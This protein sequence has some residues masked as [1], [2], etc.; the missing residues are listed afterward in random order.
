MEDKILF[1]K[2]LGLKAPWFITEVSL[3]EDNQQL[4]IYIEHTKG[5]RFPCPKCEEFCGV[6]DH[7]S[8]R[9]FRHLNVWQAPAYL[10]VR[11][12]RVD[13]L[14]HG[15]QQIT[16]GLA[17]GNSN[18]TYEFESQVLDFEQECS[19]ESTCRLLDLSWHTA[20]NIQQ[21]AVDRGFSRKELKVP[22]RIGVDEKS[23]TKGHKYETLVYN[24]DRGTVE[25]VCDNREQKSLESYYQQFSP[26]K[27]EKV[28]SVSMDM[29]VPFIAATKAYIPNAQE[30][31]V[32]DR[33][34][35]MKYVTEAVDKTRKQEHAILSENGNN[36]LKG[37]KYLFLWNEENI[38]EWRRDDFKQLRGQDLKVCKAWAIKENIRNMWNYRYKACMRKYFDKW[39]FWATHSRIKPVIKAA[40]TLKNHIENIVTYAKHRI[41]NALGESLNSKI[42][43][44]KRLACGFRNREHYRTAI[45]FHCGGL[46]LYPMRKGIALQIIGA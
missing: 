3:S 30:K 46:E 27:L 19:I 20:W 37:S 45:Y 5:T 6:Y 41:T 16:H 9:T 4:D 25:Y 1:T 23:F 43:K 28:S 7:T 8:E 40:K 15:I 18:L 38:P 33:F 31:I 13:C 22:L 36:I 17:D 10:H 29:W 12:P 32:F 35:V 34:H 26:E 42:E 11:I 14:V 39:Y 44:V 24:I 21:R 2:L